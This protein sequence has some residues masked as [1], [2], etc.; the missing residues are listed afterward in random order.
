MAAAAVQQAP[1]PT[2][3][4]KGH[5]SAEVLQ[6]RSGIARLTRER[7]ARTQA[8]HLEWLI[9]TFQATRAHHTGWTASQGPAGV[10]ARC[11]DRVQ[12]VQEELKQLQLLVAQIA[13]RDGASEGGRSACSLDEPMGDADGSRPQQEQQRRPHVADV[14][15]PAGPQAA[16]EALDARHPD[17]AAEEEAKETPD[18]ANGMDIDIA[19]DEVGGEKERISA[20][21]REEARKNQ[22]Q[23]GLDGIREDAGSSTSELEAV[24]NQA[25]LFEAGA[26]EHQRSGMATGVAVSPEVGGADFE[27]ASEQ[28]HSMGRLDMLKPEDTNSKGRLEAKR[29]L[30]NYCLTIRDALS[31][32]KVQERSEDDDMV[33]SLKAVQA[34]LN[35]L[36]KNPLA[37][38]DEFEA[39]LKVLHG[40]VTS[41]L[42]TS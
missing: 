3:P 9:S 37:L 34:T 33:R 1:Q 24:R 29:E 21:H 27:N 10:L 7:R 36:G 15:R 39:R 31:I 18:R 41:V 22:S 23:P 20:E 19:I 8:R 17:C 42:S 14:P 26:G 30:E 11:E 6:P 32:A 40:I 12:R 25:G 38:Q 5:N 16:A 35:W 4:H 2:H 13:A 28:D